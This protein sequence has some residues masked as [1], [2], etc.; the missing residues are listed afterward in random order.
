MEIRLLSK[1]DYY[2]GYL[3]VLNQLTPVH[4]CSF[5]E[6]CNRFDIQTKHNPNSETYVL[7]IDK[8]I[9]ATG[10]ILIELKMHNNFS[11]MGHIEDIVVDKYH[12]GKG[13]GKLITEYLKNRS[14]ES[15]CYK[16]V[17]SCTQN[18]VNFYEKCGFKKKGCEMVVYK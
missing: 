17:L 7:E 4:D 11:N 6:F 2:K 8:K 13:Y 5:E 15:G 10:K 9:V 12:R 3:S 1:N 14:L 18:N 16:V